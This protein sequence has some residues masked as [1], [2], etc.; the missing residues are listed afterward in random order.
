M[1]YTVRHIAQEHSFA[2]SMWRMIA[3]PDILIYLD[4]SFAQASKRGE[5]NWKLAD[6]EE[7][8]RRL[9]HARQHTDCRI[10]TDDIS[11][12]AVFDQVISFM[13]PTIK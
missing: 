7:E 1:G 13:H 10:H 2:P 12:Q 3:D 9:E 8:L 6:F 5:L 4:V 11:P